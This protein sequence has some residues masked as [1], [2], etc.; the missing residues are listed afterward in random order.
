MLEETFQPYSNR[1]CK[2]RRKRKGAAR[3]EEKPSHPN[4][5]REVSDGFLLSIGY[6]KI[7]SFHITAGDVVLNSY[8]KGPYLKCFLRNP[9]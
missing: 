8:D 2:C 4:Q 5:L 7:W 9:A 1:G 6:W 3:G